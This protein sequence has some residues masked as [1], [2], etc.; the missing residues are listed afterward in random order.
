MPTLQ[1]VVPNA[2]AAGPSTGAGLSVVEIVGILLS[3]G[4]LLLR[5]TTG[6]TTLPLW[7][8]DPMVYSV[9]MSGVG[10]ALSMVLDVL[11]LMGA[12][13][14]L[15]AQRARGRGVSTLAVSLAAVGAIPVLWHAMAGGGSL[16]DQ[17]IGFSWMAGIFGAVG[18]Y[19][20]AREPAVR[21]LLAAVVLGFLALLAI[22]SFQQVF[23]DHPQTVADFRQSKAQLLAAHGWA[24]GSPSALAF[25][26]RLSQ[27]E[28]SGWFGLSNV[29]ATLASGLSVA[30]IGLAT[31]AW[32]KVHVPRA[33]AAGVA[34][35]AIAGLACLWLAGA[36]GG[37]LSFVAGV[38]ALGV[39][40]LLAR[41]ASS[42]P[43]LGRLL[44]GLIGPAAVLGALALVAVRGAIGERLGELSLLFRWFYA[45]G[46]MRIFAE[47]PL[48]G[49]GPDGF[50]SAYSLAKPPLSV[51]DVTS[52]HAV[53]YD[54]IATLGVL[55]AAWI[56]LLLLA[57]FVAGR[58]AASPRHAAEPE[59]AGPTRNEIRLALALP[60]AATLAAA[61]LE[62]SLRSP[63]AITVRIVGLL[64]HRSRRLPGCSSSCSDWRPLRME[65]R[66]SDAASRHRSGRSRRRP[67]PPRLPWSLPSR[68]SVPG[69]GNGT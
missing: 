18:V 46:A 62:L 15:L 49:V 6:T 69:S 33:A 43:R 66:P 41:A 35:L 17:R 23:I 40:S 60:A 64:R 50:Q 12:A 24:P 29:L 14:L 1:R 4:P 63:D 19:H 34:G 32:R 59:P 3:L 54:W 13:C 58:G 48:L 45:Q 2:S 61:F 22:K 52:P 36:K 20:A 28:A 51:E 5:A 30:A 11:V 8:L 10:P 31:A 25:E 47:H 9:P 16:N 65:R 67:S 42:N 68:H 21:R 39:L 53:V 56:A 38:S 37:W 7:D 27:P 44:A 55:G 26:R 57:G